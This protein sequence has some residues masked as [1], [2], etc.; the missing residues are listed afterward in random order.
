MEQRPNGGSGSTIALADALW[1]GVRHHSPIPSASG[2]L[3]GWYLSGPYASVVARRRARIWRHRSPE[4][5]LT[6]QWL[7]DR[8]AGGRT[9]RSSLRH[10]GFPGQH[11]YEV[12][13]RSVADGRFDAPFLYVAGYSRSGT[14]SVQNLILAAFDDH[15]PPG[16][17]DG[18]GH[19]LRL[20][21]YPKH[22]PHVARRIAGLGTDVARVVLCIRPF[23]D[24]AASLAL[25]NGLQSP[26]QITPQWVDWNAHEWRQLAEIAVEDHVV[27][28]PFAMLPGL[29]PAEGTSFLAE[30]LG[31]DPDRPVDRET[32]W[33]DIYTGRISS[34][35]IGNPHLGNLPHV[36]RPALTERLRDRITDLVGS[37]AELL[38]DTY[39][40]AV[41][42]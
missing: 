37:R 1:D 39:L 25:Y 36:E 38:D 28:F 22:N 24:S 33:D 30:Q 5:W 35:E 20:W 9:T 13:Y 34:E 31:V 8:A 14:T 3:R 27:C 26:D 18:P 42:S 4:P 10:D 23:V 16:Q 21:W 11:S 40:A 29:T 17:W 32:T 19:P 12:A 41:S 15:V 6:T 7:L 2:G